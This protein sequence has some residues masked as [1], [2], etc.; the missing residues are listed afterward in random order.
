MNMDKIHVHTCLHITSIE[1]NA[2]NKTK[3]FPSPFLHSTSWFFILTEAFWND[4]V[5]ACSTALRSPTEKNE[6]GGYV[7]DLCPSKRQSVVAQR[8]GLNLSDVIRLVTTER[9]RNKFSFLESR[10]V[11]IA[12]TVIANLLTLSILI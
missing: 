9:I 1:Y 12:V 7:T 6:L 3:P 8:I 4:Y 5:A 11:I 2:G 10:S